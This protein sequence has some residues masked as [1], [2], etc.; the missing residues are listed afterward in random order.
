MK[1]PNNNLLILLIMICFLS[2]V[3][4]FY[5]VSQKQ[6]NSEELVSQIN[7][8]QTEN[9]N[10]RSQIENLNTRINE[11]ENKEQENIQKCVS[12]L[13]THNVGFI[14]GK[15]EV[16]FNSIID[17]DQIIEDIGLEK[18]AGNLKWAVLKVPI[19][20]EIEWV[21]KLKS[22]PYLEYSKLYTIVSG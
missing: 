18:G 4:L 7:N 8:L 16:G 15:I 22:N 12:Y 13:D 10:L 14:K 3:G 9:E 21:C 19:G 2:I 5:V 11:L 6:K 17:T 20:S 1:K